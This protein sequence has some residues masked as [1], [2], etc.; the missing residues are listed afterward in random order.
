MAMARTFSARRQTFKAA[1][2]A[3]VRAAARVAK[4]A[5]VPAALVEL[6]AARAARQKER[7]RWWR[8]LGGRP[9]WDRETRRR[10]LRVREAFARYGLTVVVAVG[11]SSA[12][13]VLATR[14]AIVQLQTELAAFQARANDRFAA[15]Q[16]EIER[17]SSY[18]GVPPPL[19]RGH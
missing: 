8:N 19:N 2:S 15:Q 7:R 16:R 5:R 4:T 10:R 17:I 11:G 12:S 9:H 13:F 14:E 18:F 6:R 3:R 1:R